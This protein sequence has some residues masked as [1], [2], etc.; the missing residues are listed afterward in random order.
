MKN[1]GNAKSDFSKQLILEAL[2]DIMEYQSLHQISVKEICEVAMVSRKTFYRNFDHKLDVINIEVARV[3]KVYM[4]S[5]EETSDLTL[6]NIAFLVF[7]LVNKH[8]RF[9]E[10]IVANHLLFLVSERI[11]QEVMDV[12]KIRKQTLFD[13]YGA[14]TIENVLHFSFGGFEHYIKRLLKSQERVSA[15]QIRREFIKISEILTLSI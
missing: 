3:I 7:D 1:K 6:A 15:E 4:A 2:L 14:E 13:Q 10:K 12:Y 8:K 11:L 5:I 9:F